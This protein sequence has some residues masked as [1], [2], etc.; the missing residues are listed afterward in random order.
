[1]SDK[2]RYQY[3]GNLLGRCLICGAIRQY[4]VDVIPS[5]NECNHLP[6]CRICGSDNCEGHIQ[7]WLKV[8]PGHKKEVVRW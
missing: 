3:V 8:Y 4:P 2:P 6:L 5:I 7:G 1:M